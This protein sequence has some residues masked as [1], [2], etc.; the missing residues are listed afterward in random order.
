L[1]AFPAASILVGLRRRLCRSDSGA[2]QTVAGFIHGTEIEQVFRVAGAKSYLIASPTLSVKNQHPAWW[3]ALAAIWCDCGA[4][5]SRRKTTASRGIPA[6]SASA[7]D[8]LGKKHTASH[9][10]YHP[11]STRPDSVLHR[12][13][14]D[15]AGASC[16]RCR[17][18]DQSSR[19][20]M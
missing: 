1:A 19:P 6:M 12:P 10:P 3:N 14:A 8:A 17:F 11:Q 15:V 5:S 2:C 4:A 18:F 9:S 13:S 7:I 20:G 16:L